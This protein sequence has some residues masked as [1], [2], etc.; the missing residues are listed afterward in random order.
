MKIF[1]SDFAIEKVTEI[2]EYINRDNPQATEKWVAS[3]F[4]RVKQLENFPKSGRVVPEINRSN[5]REIFFGSYRIVYK[6]ETDQI[7]ILTVR[8]G[9]QILPVDEIEG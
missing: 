4:D 1:W 3:I 8:H 9:K 5:I 6:I 7:V 2:A